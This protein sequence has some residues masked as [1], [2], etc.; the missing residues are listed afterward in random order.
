MDNNMPG[1][2]IKMGNPD[3][4]THMRRTF[5]RDEHRGEGEALPSPGIQVSRKSSETWNHTEHR[6]DTPS[7]GT[8]PAGILISD[9]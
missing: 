5:C 2:L 3:A 8:N 4:K 6:A 9:F 7:E 1:V